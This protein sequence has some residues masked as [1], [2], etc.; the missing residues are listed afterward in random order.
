M[1][2]K[3]EIPTIIPVHP[4]QGEVDNFLSTLFNKPATDM[5]CPEAL[6]YIDQNTQKGH[7]N[8]CK[9]PF[10]YTPSDESFVFHTKKT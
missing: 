2:N 9:A 4:Y 5:P 8:T 7:C 3:H 1:P 6:G 10:T